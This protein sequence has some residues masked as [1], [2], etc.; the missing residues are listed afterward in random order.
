M[1]LREMAEER[2]DAGG[3]PAVPPAPRRSRA[4]ENAPGE[5]LVATT[6][7]RPRSPC[8][9]GHLGGRSGRPRTSRR[10]RGPSELS[11]YTTTRRLDPNREAGSASAPRRCSCRCAGDADA[12]GGLVA[13]WGQLSLKPIEAVR[14]RPTTAFGEGR[15]MLA[16]PGRAF[17]ISPRPRLHASS[18]DSPLTREDVSL[19]GIDRLRERQ[20]PSKTATS[21]GAVRRGKPCSS[22]G[23]PRRGLAATLRSH[24][25]LSAHGRS[26]PVCPSEERHWRGPGAA[27]GSAL[28]T[29][30]TEIRWRRAPRSL[31]RSGEDRPRARGAAHARRSD[32]PG[33]HPCIPSSSRCSPKTG[34]TASPRW[35]S[36][37]DLGLARGGWRAS[38][39]VTTL[40]SSSTRWPTRSSCSRA[41]IWS[42]G[43]V[44]VCGVSSSR[45]SCSSAA[46]HHPMSEGW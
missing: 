36:P 4:A 17:V 23:E 33:A 45:A 1:P 29:R 35:S 31:S 11:A 39:Q 18:W 10:G 34:A 22:R 8:V 46:A 43:R 19:R 9:P 26:S 37:P 28:A 6:P 38:R 40:G 20:G 3:G 21:H 14:G 12:A 2:G 16:R 27:G 15:R 41:G 7:A 44:P 25:Q 32:D 30:R 13:S 24:G 42:P 5:H